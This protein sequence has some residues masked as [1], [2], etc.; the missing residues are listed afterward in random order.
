MLPQLEWWED[1]SGEKPILDCCLLNNT[2]LFAQFCWNP[3][4]FVPSAAD[5]SPIRNS[6]VVKSKRIKS[7]RKTLPTV[8]KQSKV[9]SPEKAD[10][11]FARVIE[12]VYGG[13]RI[14]YSPFWSCT[15]ARTHA[16]WHKCD[17]FVNFSSVQLWSPLEQPELL[18]VIVLCGYTLL[19]K[20]DLSY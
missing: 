20:G 16:W 17:L 9:L 19:L 4:S 6:A 18:F 12:S 3:L 15:G 11:I 5:I 8:N 10:F 7:G 1:R 14:C 2:C 13:F